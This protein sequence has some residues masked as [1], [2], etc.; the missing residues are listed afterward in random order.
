MDWRQRPRPASRTPC[1]VIFL[2]Q[3]TFTRSNMRRIR[4]LW[5]PGRQAASAFH[6][7]RG[8]I[9]GESSPREFDHRQFTIYRDAPRGTQFLGAD[10]IRGF[11]AG[12]V[13]CAD[14]LRLGLHHAVIRNRPGRLVGPSR[15]SARFSSFDLGS[16][17]GRA[18]LR[19]F[20]CSRVA[21]QGC[22]RAALQGRV[23]A[24]HTHRP[25]GPVAPLGLKPGLC[26]SRRGA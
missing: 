7:V 25:S 9:H 15:V 19:A 13:R 8:G 26:S 3:G 22:G 5:Q 16:G 10:R 2:C 4:L 24:R 14:L 20:L 12:P 23:R 17:C 11:R 6:L 18:A 1:T 21:E